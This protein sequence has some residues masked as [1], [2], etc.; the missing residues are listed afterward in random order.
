MLVNEARIVRYGVVGSRRRNSPEDREIVFRLVREAPAGVKFV[1]GGCSEGADF[2]VKEACE[3]YGR[4]LTEHLPKLPADGSPYW[5]FTKAYHARNE[6]IAQD[7]I[8]IYAL[9][10]PDR[11][12][13]TENTLKHARRLGKTIVLL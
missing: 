9:V 3:L 5:E 12:G 10:A 7:A 4:R 1:S 2:F 6:L 11:K 8:V 13:G